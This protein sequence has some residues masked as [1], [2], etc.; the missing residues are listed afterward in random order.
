M[1]AWGPWPPLQGTLTSSSLPM[2]WL[3]P[4]PNA[5]TAA[6]VAIGRPRPCMC[7]DFPQM[8][9]H[10]FEYHGKGC[11]RRGLFQGREKQDEVGAL[12]TAHFPS[13]LLKTLNVTTKHHHALSK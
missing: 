11:S 10:L 3:S 13:C 2:K 12:L 6:L 9:L 8:A 5:T 7:M 1:A 4:S